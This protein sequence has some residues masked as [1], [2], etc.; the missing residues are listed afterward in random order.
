MTGSIAFSWSC[1][2]LAASVTTRSLPITWKPIWF[3]ISGITGL[4]LPGMIDE[5]ACMAGSRISPKPARGPLDRRRRSLQIFES[6]TDMRLSAPEIETKAPVSDVAST[7][8]R[9]GRRVTPEMRDRCAQAATEN[10]AGA[11]TPVPIAVPPRLTSRISS[12]APR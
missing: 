11:L 10:S 4:T 8:L 9:A 12:A 2:A 5:P 1:P 7:R 6:F 3:S